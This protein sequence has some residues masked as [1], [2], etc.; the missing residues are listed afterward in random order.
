MSEAKRMSDKNAR[1]GEDMLEVLADDIERY[2][3]L[4]AKETENVFREVEGRHFELPTEIESRE[5]LDN[6]FI[7]NKLDGLSLERNCLLF[8]S[9]SYLQDGYMLKRSQNP[10][11]F[12]LKPYFHFS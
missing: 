3:L 2:E 11:Y 1:N 8:S 10:Q 7:K 9:F 12:G 5:T 6:T 4:S